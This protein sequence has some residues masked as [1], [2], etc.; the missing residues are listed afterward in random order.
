MKYNLLKKDRFINP[1]VEFKIS[2]TLIQ[3]TQKQSV[4]I[5]RKFYLLHH[6]IEIREYMHTFRPCLKCVIKNVNCS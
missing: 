6:L 3:L 2:L 4:P 1:F 5:T